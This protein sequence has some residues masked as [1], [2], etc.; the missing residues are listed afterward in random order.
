L[1]RAAGAQ[2]ELARALQ[3]KGW[4]YFRLGELQEALRL[5]EEALALS[6]ALQAHREMGFSLNVLGGAHVMLGHFEEADDYLEQALALYRELGNRERVAV[7][8]NNLGENARMRGDY[9]DAVVRYQE[10]LA[11]AREIGYRDLEIMALNN[12]GAAKV[13]QG[14][15]LAAEADLRQAMGMAE[16]A[17]AHFGLGE[18]Y[19]FLAEALLG[20]AQEEGGQPRGHAEMGAALEKALAA[21]RRGLELTQDTGQP[22]L[23]GGAWRTLGLVGGHLGVSIDTGGNDYDAAGCFEESLRIFT[24]GGMEGERA[25][26]LKAWAEY[27]LQRGNREE[28]ERGEAMWQE[29]RETFARLGMG[30]EVERMAQ[31]PAENI[32]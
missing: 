2:V 16:A 31:M 3:A 14:E 6:S 8:L 18:T 15:H 17:G 12:L 22:D 30:F 5:G 13:G 23:I 32:R 1:A 10:A 20:L 27:A 9:P 26:T 25:R 24:E 19:R 4:G 21:A 7:M 29:A 11:I 28:R